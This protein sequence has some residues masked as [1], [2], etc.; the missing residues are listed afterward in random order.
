A[1][2]LVKLNG[3]GLYA[4]VSSAL[5]VVTGLYIVLCRVFEG[6]IGLYRFIN[7]FYIGETGEINPIK[8]LGFSW[9]AGVLLIIIGAICLFLVKSARLDRI[10]AFGGNSPAYLGVFVPVL[11]GSVFF[12]CIR[13]IIIAGVCNASDT[14]IQSTY[15]CIKEY[16]FADTFLFDM[17]YVTYLI[18]TVLGVLLLGKMK[19]ALPGRIESGWLLPLLLTVIAVV[20]SVVYYFNSPPLFGYLTVDEKLC[21]Y[22]ESAYPVYMLLYI[23]D[24]MF[25]MAAVKLFFDKKCSMKK[26]LTTC[27]NVAV[28]SI[29]GILIAVFVTKFHTYGLEIFYII[30][31][32]VDVIGLFCLFYSGN[33]RRSHH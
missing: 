9:I 8:M 19:L 17:P 21:D 22:I 29:I 13:E 24:M 18:I 11:L 23:L 14:Y 16:Y 28:V 27:C 7:R 10:K 15:L 2:M 30:C 33:I 4:V 25:L 3:A 26:M 6:N 1:A 20:R 12:E 5:S 31:A 32:T